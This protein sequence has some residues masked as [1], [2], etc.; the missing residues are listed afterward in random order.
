ME[1]LK[2]IKSE[3]VYAIDIE[4][5]SIVDK[6]EDASDVIKKAWSYKMEYDNKDIN[7]S[8]SQLWDLKS[9]L[10]PEFSKICAIST[11]FLNKTQDKLIC[12]SHK[13]YDEYELL[14]DVSVMLNAI[15]NSD[16]DNRLIVN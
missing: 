11:T 2:S 3:K 14:K 1:L 8:D 9:S 10:Y 4:T 15:E 13:S 5:V 12:K 7:L 16:G 6:F